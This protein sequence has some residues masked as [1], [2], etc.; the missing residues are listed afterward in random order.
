M[1]FVS[2]TDFQSYWQQANEN[3]QSS[4]SGCHFGHYKAASFDRYLLAMHPANLTLAA[5]TGVPLAHWG[6]GLMVLLKKVFGNIYIDKMRAICLLE[7]N[8]NWLNKFVFAKQMMDKAFQGYIIPAEQ[9]AKRGSQATEGVLTSGLF[10]DIARALHKTTPI[11]S[12]DLAN[13]YG[14][15]ARPIA[16]IALQSF[17]VCKVIVAMMLYVVE[18]MT[19]YLKTVFGQSK[20]SFSG[21]AFDISMGLGQGNGAS[22]PDFLAV[23]TLMIKVYH[24]LGHG[25]TVIRA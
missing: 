16:S 7:A 9:F 21:T 3:I 2:T 22:P 4:E 5:S 12:V 17:K 19:W 14:A 15:V 1:D 6:N 18:T 11:E 20:I 10:C 8:Y 24:N 13:C 25:V 23:C